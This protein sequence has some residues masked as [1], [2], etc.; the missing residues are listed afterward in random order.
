MVF[1][2]AGAFV[3]GVFVGT[4]FGILVLSLCAMA[5]RSEVAG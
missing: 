1:V 3:I 2:V 4:F 5:K